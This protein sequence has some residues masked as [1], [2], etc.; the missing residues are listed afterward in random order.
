MFRI[1]CHL[2]ISGGYAAMIREALSIGA[3]NVQF[4]TRNPRGGRSRPPDPEDMAEY[5]RIAAENS[6]GP[7]LAHAPYTMNP[8][9][10]RPE[11]RQYALET[12][13]DDLSRLSAIPGS[14]Y[15]FHPG[16]HVSQ[17][18]DTGI[19][20]IATLLRELLQSGSPTVIL[21]ETMA[22]KGSEVGGT[23]EE[24]ARILEQAGSPGADRVG[25]CLDTCHVYDAGYDI[26]GDLDGVL[27]EF[28]RILGLERLK[29]VHLND[30][31]F[32][33]QSH[34]DRHELIGQGALGMD[35]V[36][37]VITHPS[38]RDLP[39]Y[40]E[41]PNDVPGYGREIAMLRELRGD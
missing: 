36:L 22:G 18:T 25:V 21:L 37:R 39:F 29:A 9:A 19:A 6:F 1:G 8:A 7:A 34:K 28:D 24:L 17:G 12:M 16:C 31:K 10:A 13:L 27:G 23:F 33:F 40:L 3:S 5:N 2:S 35:A 38:L 41:T 32:G 11:L 4:F 14:M 30:S 26:A 15:N 20:L